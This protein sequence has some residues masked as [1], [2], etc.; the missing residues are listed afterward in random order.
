[1]PPSEAGGA[2]VGSSGADD[3]GA[4]EIETGVAFE[5]D[6]DRPREAEL[7]TDGDGRTG[8]VGGRDIEAP[9][10]IADVGVIW[11]GRLSTSAP[12]DAGRA[13]AS[14]RP[15]ADGVMNSLTGPAE[16]FVVAAGVEP[17]LLAL[18]QRR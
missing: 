8:S 18:P 11:L 17:P 12:D 1:V 5:V 9:T 13:V 10:E 3:E 4:T 14:E 15:S 6:V 7:M 16:S 2:A